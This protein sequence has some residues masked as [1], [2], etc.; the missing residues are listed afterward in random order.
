LA[1]GSDTRASGGF[2]NHGDHWFHLQKRGVE[3]KG[4]PGGHYTGNRSVTKGASADPEYGRTSAPH[5]PLLGD[6]PMLGA[7]RRGWG[8][9]CQV[10]TLRA[11]TTRIPS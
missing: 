5:W 2:C 10:P 3:P 6:S 1:A 4:A 9:G 8:Y 11:A 7:D